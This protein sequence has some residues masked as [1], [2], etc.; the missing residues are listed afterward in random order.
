[1]IVLDTNVVSEL[2]RPQP[3]E[4]V[5]AWVAQQSPHD[6]FTA[7]ITKGEILYGIAI[8]PDGRRKSGLAAGAERMFRE[9]FAGRILAFDAI[10]AVYYAAILS[11][12]RLDG[13]PVG[14]L[15]AQ[16]AA[17]AV[18]VGASVATRN[19]DDFTGCGLAIINPWVEA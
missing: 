14:P 18:A 16:I 6:L 5:V 4:T 9:Y 8:M 2:M 10:A 19:V 1:M 7:S 15:D 13:N 3:H 17:I 11:K 12:R